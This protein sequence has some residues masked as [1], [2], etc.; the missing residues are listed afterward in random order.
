MR[1]TG[2]IEATIRSS[3]AHTKENENENDDKLQLDRHFLYLFV[4]AEKKKECKRMIAE[5]C[6]CVCIKYSI[7]PKRNF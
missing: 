7:E 1:I 6:V 2:N 3:S 4:C 5:L